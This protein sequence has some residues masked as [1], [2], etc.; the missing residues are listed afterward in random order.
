MPAKSY[1]FQLNMVE[2]ARRSFEYRSAL[3]AGRAPWSHIGRHRP[4]A[5]ERGSL[6]LSYKCTPDQFLLPTRP[7]F[8]TSSG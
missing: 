7:G 1:F 8:V 2:P 5:S 6:N 4:G 3:D